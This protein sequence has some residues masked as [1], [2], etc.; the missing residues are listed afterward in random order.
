MAKSDEAKPA[1]KAKAVETIKGGRFVPMD[2]GSGRKQPCLLFKGDAP[3]VGAKIKMQ[4]Q[5]GVSY[6]GVVADVTTVD[7]EHIVDFK[8]GVTPIQ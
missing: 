3:D 8:D 5:N 1:A 6:Q 4:M 2:N 7:G